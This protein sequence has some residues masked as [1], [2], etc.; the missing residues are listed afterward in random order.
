M[1]KLKS[2]FLQILIVIGLN[3][4]YISIISVEFNYLGFYYSFNSF[5]FILVSII[6]LLLIIYGELFSKN[7]IAIVWY[8][9]F[10]I[11][12]C[13]E[14]IYYQYS[15]NNNWE[16]LF[17]IVLLLI[18]LPIFSTSN[19]RL[20]TFT[21]QGDSLKILFFL[22]CV[23]FIPI[24][25]VYFR[26]I[27]FNSLLFRDVYD[28]RVAF[29]EINFPVVGYI[30]APLAMIILPISIV[31]SLEEKRYKYLIFSIFMILFIY[32][33][34]AVK[35]VF[36]GLI[37]VVL[38][39]FFNYQK[40]ILLLKYGMFGLT[41][42]SLIA[43]FLFNNLFLIDF[44]IRRVLF[45]PAYLNDICISFFR[46]NF[47]YY[48]HSPIG[49]GL[50]DYKYDQSLSFFVGTQVIGREGLNANVGV[51][52]EGYIS[53]GIYG[54]IFI[55]VLLVLLFKYFD[56]L[57]YNPKFFGIIFVYVYYLNTSFLSVLLLT[58]GL[59]FLIVVSFF[60]LSEKHE[61]RL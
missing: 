35:S 31:K 50:S 16:I 29:R 56:S 23:L 53:F 1:S 58:H 57:R 28:T 22:S 49:L 18:L 3:I 13:G 36:I 4:C 11:F 38:F 21:I 14:S 17:G 2:I 12:Y 54:V 46:E 7:F 30:R 40:K 47:T 6:T 48:A 42:S 32:M 33:A 41:I 55:V 52:T 10:F 27:N 45:V 5:R 9:F 26:H 15:T 59:L 37:G 51:I 20:K 24:F 19:R 25:L 61:K 39:Y 60:F 44:F 8:L 34:G 43:Y